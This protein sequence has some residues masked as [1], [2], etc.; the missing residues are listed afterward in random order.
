MDIAGF[1]LAVLLI[2][3]TPGPNM[4]WLAGL[5]AIE[6]RRS[7]LMA[8]AGVGLGL[9]ANGLLAALGLT[10]LLAAAPALWNALRIAGAIMM[11]WIGVRTWMSAEHS[12]SAAVVTRFP[13]HA[14]LTGLLINLLNPKAYMFFAVVVPQFMHGQTLRL[15]E[16]LV[17]AAISATIATVIH[18]AIVLAGGYARSWLSDASRTKVAR[19]AFAVAILAL[20][21][22]FLLVD[23]RWSG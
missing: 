22:S 1:A 7:G 11:A 17:L 14:F 8:V 21:A 10:A 9:L 18:L 6:G 19:R 13:R 23:L 5:A 3:L 12:E 15:R 2:E 16:A 20:A 4:A